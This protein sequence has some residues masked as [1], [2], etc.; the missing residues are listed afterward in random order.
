MAVYGEEIL[1]VLGLVLP[2]EE[3][4]DLVSKRSIGM[5]GLPRRWIE[6]TFAKREAAVVENDE[7]L[8]I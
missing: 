4:D 1:D 6:S 8:T 5:T 2:N 3:K 7:V